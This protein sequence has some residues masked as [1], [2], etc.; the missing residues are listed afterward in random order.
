MPSSTCADA[1]IL[2]AIHPSSKW[3]A[4][5]DVLFSCRPRVKMTSDDDDE[6][7]DDGSD[8]DQLIHQLGWCQRKEKRAREDE[9][10]S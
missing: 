8:D 9:D 3:A 2:G 1:S 6:E 5:A 10:Q 7:D 4:V